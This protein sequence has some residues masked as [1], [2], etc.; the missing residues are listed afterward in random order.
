MSAA[1]H[2]TNLQGSNPL[3]YL[4]WTNKAMIEARARSEEK[5]W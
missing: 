1:L 2:K 5:E 4:L 3:V